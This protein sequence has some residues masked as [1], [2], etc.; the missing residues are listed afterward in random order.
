MR[1]ISAALKIYNVLLIPM[2]MF[3]LPLR[4]HDWLQNILLFFSRRNGELYKELKD[5]E[6]LRMKALNAEQKIRVKFVALLE[7]L[8]P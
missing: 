7:F 8:L 6:E 4:Q 3:C 5:Q 2:N 1:P